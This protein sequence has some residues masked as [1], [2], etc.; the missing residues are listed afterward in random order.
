MPHSAW[1]RCQR[2]FRLTQFVFPQPNTP[3]TPLRRSLHQLRMPRPH[4]A[5]FPGSTKKLGVEIV[6][7]LPG[8]LL[9][10][11]RNAVSI[12]V[13]ILA[14]SCDLPGHLTSRFSTGNAE[15]ISGNLLGHVQVRC[16]GP[17]GGKLVAEVAV[18][19]LE[20]FGRCS[21]CRAIRPRSDAGTYWQG[22]EGGQSGIRG[23]SCLLC[24]Q[25]VDHPGSARRNP[26]FDCCCRILQPLLSHLH[27]S[28]RP[29]TFRPRTG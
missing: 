19:S 5:F 11:D 25:R 18:Q 14:N 15:V 9:H 6:A 16:W 13:G 22:P 24:Q 10:L 20:P 4:D 12:S 27:R 2:G 8:R 29:C 17:Q 26:G 23:R 1:M 21:S 28:G 3:R 7:A